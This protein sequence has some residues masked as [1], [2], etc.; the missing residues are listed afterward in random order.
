MN[1]HTNTHTIDTST[2]VISADVYDTASFHAAAD[3]IAV[4]TNTTAPDAVPLPAP[5]ASTAELLA[6]AQEAGHRAVP[7]PS[8]RPPWSPAPC[9]AAPASPSPTARSATR[10]PPS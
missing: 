9:C 10:S 8:P 6:A 1:T 5:G 7:A 2:P 4:V 3:A